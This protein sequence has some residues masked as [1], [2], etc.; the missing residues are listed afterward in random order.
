ML[1]NCRLWFMVGL[2]VLGVGGNSTAWTA[3]HP[4]HVSSAEIR[5]N[6]TTGNF[7]VALCVWPADLERA[8]ANQTKSTANLERIVDL[9]AEL[10]QYVAARFSIRPKLSDTNIT[11]DAASAQSTTESGSEKRTGE[12][13]WVGHEIDLKQ[14]WLYF[15]IPGSQ[16][17]GQWKISN[18]VFFELN[19]EQLNQVQLS[20]G[21]S[22]SSVALTHS[23]PTHDFE[24]AKKSPTLGLK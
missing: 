20:V 15:E 14:A 4:Y 12:F 6:E 17:V 3:S 11:S 5:W 24:T 9:D 1:A 16:Q 7:E 19:E 23:N 10:K 18:R 22:S 2:L 13:R 8:I 21:N